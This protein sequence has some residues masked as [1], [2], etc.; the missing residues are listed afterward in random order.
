VLHK[1]Q[2]THIRRHGVLNG[3]EGS[4]AF[5]HKRKNPD[6]PAFGKGEEISA[7]GKYL[8]AGSCEGEAF[9]PD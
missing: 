1:L 7:T 6:D 9:A 4:D 3:S 2:Y 5:E 8:R